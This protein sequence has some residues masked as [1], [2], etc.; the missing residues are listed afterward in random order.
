MNNINVFIKE[1]I[2]KVSPKNIFI[3]PEI[4]E[5]KLN[6][7]IKSFGCKDNHKAILAIYDNTIFGNAKDG[8]VFTGEKYYTKNHLKKELKYI[9]IILNQ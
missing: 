5:K 3:S 8:I 9:M 6:N 7:A 2:K 4:P 1:N